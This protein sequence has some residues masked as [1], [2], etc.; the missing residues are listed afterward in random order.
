MVFVLTTEDAEV[1]E[2]GG[3]VA[4]AWTGFFIDWFWLGL[5]GTGDGFMD[6]WC[7]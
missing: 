7:N 4:L 2:L 1:T 6:G 3:F 5:Q